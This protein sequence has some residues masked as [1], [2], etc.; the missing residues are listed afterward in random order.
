LDSKLKLDLIGEPYSYDDNYYVS[1]FTVLIMKASTS[2]SL[3]G[4]YGLLYRESSLL[5]WVRV[6]SLP[7]KKTLLYSST[8]NTIT[9]L[10]KLY[11]FVAKVY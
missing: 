8:Y 9:K 6:L 4:L 1:S 5:T 2:H 10:Y 3:M 7:E 11:K